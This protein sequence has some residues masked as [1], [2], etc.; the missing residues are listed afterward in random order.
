M[1]LAG[2]ILGEVVIRLVKAC[3]R[4]VH[5]AAQNG[6]TDLERLLPRL[7]LFVNDLLELLRQHGREIALALSLAREA[8][9]FNGLQL[10]LVG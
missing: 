3:N 8:L 2:C 1:L 9:L 7:P 5:H 6:G 10:D 4:L